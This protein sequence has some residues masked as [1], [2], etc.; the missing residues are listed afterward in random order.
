MMFLRSFLPVFMAVI[1]CSPAFASE[2]REEASSL[3]SKIEK[4]AHEQDELQADVQEL[5]AEQT[6]EE[7]ISLL[8]ECQEAMNEAI[9]HLEEKETG[10]KTIAAQTEV[11]E[12]IFKAAEKKSQS[13][14]DKSMQGMLEMMKG[15]MD[16]SE[17]SGD[18]NKNEGGSSND[19]PGKGT[20]GEGKGSSTPVQGANDG[21]KK[22]PRRLPKA[23]GSAGTEYPREFSQAM[24]AYNKTLMEKTEKNPQP[25]K[26]KK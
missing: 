20:T 15:M 14:N 22:E 19:T 23:S 24:D 7:V 10:G 17:G 9:D 4:V 2:S 12:I 1:T 8:E 16:S 5:V 18:D 21:E 25:E 13:G 26:E 11:I 3:E 6:N